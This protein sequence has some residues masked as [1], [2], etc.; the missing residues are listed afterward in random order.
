[1]RKLGLI[2][3]KTKKHAK[4]YPGCWI[5]TWMRI[6]YFIEKVIIIFNLW[7]KDDERKKM[8]IFVFGFHR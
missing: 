1:M 5:D 7:H 8:V 3:K 4:S 6:L 2:E